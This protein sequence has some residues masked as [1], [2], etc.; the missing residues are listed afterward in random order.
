MLKS[1]AGLD[2]NRADFL[3]AMESDKVSEY[4]QYRTV[5]HKYEWTETE[6][7]SWPELCNRL[8]QDLVELLKRSD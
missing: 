8:K 1:D 2:R 6:Q 4:I 7:T 3:A 5:V